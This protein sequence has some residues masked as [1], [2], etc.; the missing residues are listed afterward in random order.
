MRAEVG[1]QRLQ[2]HKRV[3]V[4]YTGWSFNSALGKR[5]RAEAASILPL[6]T[7]LNLSSFFNLRPLDRFGASNSIYNI[8]II[9]DNTFLSFIFR[10]ENFMQVVSLDDSAKS[11]H[12]RYCMG[13]WAH[14]LSSNHKFHIHE[15]QISYPQFFLPRDQ[16]IVLSIFQFR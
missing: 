15:S 13:F 8:G 10:N 2:V 3:C 7:R 14:H 9:I 6:G 16:K 5:H 4:F 11:N 12:C 1:S